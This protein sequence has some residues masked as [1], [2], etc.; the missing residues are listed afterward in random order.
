M[1]EQDVNKRIASIS[2]QKRELLMQL[3]ERKKKQ[4]PSPAAAEKALP[5]RAAGPSP[6]SFAQQ[7]LWFMDQWETEN[8]FS[9]IPTAVILRGVLDPGALARAIEAVAQRH[10]ILRTTFQSVEGQLLQIVAPQPT[11]ALPLEDLS[12]LPQAERDAALHDRLAR[13]ARSGFDLAQGPLFRTLLFKLSSTEHVLM[14]TMHHIVTDGWSNAV[15]FREVSAFYTAFVTSPSVP[16]PGAPSGVP[17]GSEASPAAP[18]SPSLPPLPLQ[19]ADYALWQRQHLDSGVRERQVAYWKQQLAGASALELPTDRPRPA[20]NRY[21]GTSLVFHVPGT[22]REKVEALCRRAGV[23][24]FMALLGALQLLLARLSGADE[25]C[26]GSP[27]AGRNRADLEGLIG[28]FLNNLVLRTDLSGDPTALELL[29][30]VRKVALGAYD[31]QDVPFEQVV[32][33][34]Q[35]PRDPSRTPLFQ[36]MFV[37]QGGWIQE[38]RLGDLALSP[39]EVASSISKFDLTWALADADDGFQGWIEYNT[40]LFDRA[41]VERFAGHYGTLLDAL[42][43]TPEK[44]ISELPL[45]SEA[46]RHRALVDWNDTA[47]PYPT[48]TCLHELF[49]Q[50]AACTP[51]AIAVI[52]PDRRLTYR[53][54]ER[55]ANRLAHALRARGATPNTLAAVVIRKG[56]AQVVAALA[57]LKAGAAYVPIDPG[58]PSDRVRHLLQH[59]EVTLALTHSTLADVIAWPPGV[60]HFVVDADLDDLSEADDRAPTR[61]QGPLDLAYVIYTSGSTGVPKGVMI[62]HRGPVNTIVDIN[63]RFRVGPVDRVLAL[64]ALNFDLSVYDVFGLLAV[65]GALVL[66]ESDAARDPAYWAELIDRERIT[67][68]NTVPALMEM[69]VDH[70]AEH[71][72]SPHGPSIAAAPLPLRAALLSGDWIPVTLPDRLKRIIPGIVVTSLGGAT[73][74]SIWSILYPIDHVDPTW[75]S[76]PYGRAMDNQRF[77]VLD[78]ALSPCPIGVEGDLYIGGIGVALGYWRAEEIT[79]A[80][81]ITDPRT[82]ERLYRTGDAGRYMVDGN[83]EFLGRRDFQVKIRGF[84]IELGEIEVTLMNHPSVREALVVVREDT[85]GDRRLVAY[86]VGNDGTEPDPAVLKAHAQDKLPEYM[87]P[88]AF[89]ALPAMPLTPNGKVDRRALPRPET[90]R[91]TLAEHD[92]DF[93]APRSPHETTLAGIW[94]EVIGL[95]RVGIHDNFFSLGG[96]SILAIQVVNRAKRAGISLAVR[97]LFQHQTIAAL[98]VLSDGSERP[99]AEQGPVTG[100]VV[101][102]P[103]QRWFFEQDRSAPEHFNQAVLAEIDERLDPA[104]VTQAVVHLVRHHDALRLRFVREGGEVQQR[105]AEVSDETPFTFVTLPAEAR[106]ADAGSQRPTEAQARAIVAAAEQAQASLRL[107]TGPLLRVVLMDLGEGQPSR[108]LFVVH[109]LAIDGVSWRILLEDFQTAYA[110]LRAGEEVRFPPKTSSFQQWAERLAAHAQTEAVRRELPHWLAASAPLPI[111]RDLPGGENLASSSATVERTLDPEETRALLH[112]LPDV[113]RTQINDVLLTALTQAFSAWTG[114]RA[115]QL[116]LEGHGREDLGDDLDLSRTVGWFTALYPV[117]LDLPDGGPGERLKAIKEQLRRIPRRG[118]G[119][120]LLRYLATEPDVSGALRAHP[121]ADV[122]FNYQGHVEQGPTGER[123][124]RAAEEPS[125]APHSPHDPRTHL[126]EIGAWIADGRLHLRWTYSDTTH[127]RATLERLADGF[128]TA[129]RELLAH[130]REPDAGGRTPADFPLVR[131]TQSALDRLVGHGRDVEDLYPLSP[132]QQGMLFHSLRDPG[133]GVYV[134]QLAFR[135][136]G[137]LD[138]AALQASWQALLARHPILRTAFVHGDLDEP[139]QLVRP[140]AALTWIQYDWRALPPAERAAQL[141]AFM[142]RD[143]ARGFDLADAPLMRLTV[144]R[145]ED[146]AHEL[147]W[148][149]HHLLLDGWSL[150]IVFKDLLTAYDA[151]Q[152]GEAPRLGA[153]RP[154]R[155]YIAW[156]AEQD[157][158]Q[159]EAFWRARLRGFQAPTPLPADRRKSAGAEASTQRWEER[160]LTPEITSALLDLSRAHG[161]T[162][163]T[164]LQGAWAL[165]LGRSSGERDVVFGATVSGRSASVDGIEEMVGLFINTPPVRVRC[166]ADATLV[167]WLQGL[168]AQQA[169]QLPYEYTPLT[170]VQGFSEVARGEPLFES[171]LVVENYPM[172]AALQQSGGPLRV[173]DVRA[174]EQ[175]SYPLTVVAAVDQGI[176]LRLGYDPARFEG[177]TILRLLDHLGALLE[178]ITRRPEQTVASLSLLTPA[179][180]TQV[181]TTWNDTETTF[182]TDLLVHR[183]IEAQAARTPD[184]IALTF[185][186]EHLTYRALNC[187]ANQLA[188]ALRAHGV[189]P[190]VLVGVAAERSFELVVA[191]L[192]TLKAGGAYVPLDPAYPTERLRLMIEE[193]RP[194]VILTQQ[195]LH[196][197]LPDDGPPAL[198]LDAE[199]PQI[200]EER[201]ADL[202]LSPTDEGLVYVIYTSGSTGRPKGVMNNHAGLRNRL[203][204]M[205][206]AYG[207]TAEDVVLQKTPYSFDVSVWEF[208]W[209]LMFGARL[210]VA[211][212]EGHRDP[213]YLRDLI[214]AEGVTTLHFVPSMLKAMVDH[215][216]L[217]DCASVKRVICSGEALPFDL[218]ERFF[219]QSQA[220]LHNLYGPTEAS[221]DVT[222]WACRP[223]DPRGVV[224]IGAPIA[225]TRI[226]ILDER[227]DPTPVGVPGELYIGG[228][229][230]ARGYLRRPDLTAARFVPDPHGPPGARLY[231][232]G[233]RVR[234][235]DDGVIEYLERLDFQVKIR[236]FRIELGEIEAA[237]VQHPAVRDGVVVVREDASGEPRLVAYLVPR[238]APEPAGAQA[239][240]DL[241]P[242]AL[243]AFLADRLPGHMIPAAFVSVPAALPLTSSGKV[244][245]RALPAPSAEGQDAARTLTSPRTPTEEILAGIWAEVLGTSTI[246]AHDDFFALGGHSLLATQVV[247]RARRSFS[248]ELPL[249]TVFD[250]PT[251]TALA[252]RIDIARGEGVKP[253]L[254]ALRRVTS[255]PPDAA[256]A[257]AGHPLSF[258]QQRMWV[259]DQL[260]PGSPWYNIPLAVRIDGPLDVAVL[261]RCLHDLAHRHEPLRTTF[262]TVEGEPRQIIAA[263]G[264]IPLEIVEVVTSGE[265]ATGS[266]AVSTTSAAAAAEALS[267]A[268]LQALLRDE[269]CRPFDLATGPLV[270]ARLVKLGEARHAF[271]LTMHHIVADGWSIGVIMKELALLYAARVEGAPATLPPLEIQYADYAAWQHQWLQGDTLDAQLTF[272]KQHLAGALDPLEL[273]TDCPRPALQSPR[274]KTRPL[275]IPAPLK[276]ALDALC[277]REGV[278]LFMALLAGFQ[279]LLGRY[280]G[281]DTVLV[282][283]PVAGRTQAATEDLVG[284]F[285]NTLV[286][287]ADLGD[288]PTFRELLARVKRSTLDAYAH[289]DT[290]FEKLVSALELPRDTSRPPLF[291]AM[292]VLQNLPRA[293]L[294]SGALTLHPIALATET[295]KF[296][297]TLLLDETDEGLRGGLEYSTALFDAA[298]IDRMAEAFEAFLTR[299]AQAPDKRLSALSAPPEPELHTLLSVWNAPV[300]EP[301]ADLCA[302]HLI[303]QQVARTPDAPAVTLGDVTLTYAELD[304][305]ANALAHRLQA[306]GVGPDV[307]VAL[308]LDRSPELIVALLGVLKAGGAYVPLDPSYPEERVAFMLDDSQAAVVV[309]H[310]RVPGR[311]PPAAGARH[312]LLADDGWGAPDAPSAPDASGAPHASS[313]PPKCPATPSNLAYLLYTSGSTGRPKGVMVPH[314]GLASYLRWSAEAYGMASGDGVPVHSSLAF[315]L[316]VTSALAPLTVGQR[317]HLIPEGPGIEHLTTALNEGRDHALLKLTPSHLDALL[318]DPTAQRSLARVRSFVVGGEALGAST[319]TALRTHAP[320]ARILNEYGPTETVVGCALWEVPPDFTPDQPVL[321]GKPIPGARLYVLDAQGTPAPIGVRGELCIGG[322]GVTRGY[323]GRPA[324]TAERFVPDPFAT[325]P[326]AR[327]YRSGD[328]ARF[329]AD[330]QLDYLGRLDHQVKVR[331]YRIE[332]GEIEHALTA[333]P[334]LREAVVLARDD[335]PS[336]RRLVG[337]LVPA[338]DSPMPSMTALREALA[339]TLPAYMVPSAFVVLDA[340]PL[341][342]NG[343]VDR[344]A[345]PSPDAAPSDPERP[346]IA[347]ATPAEQILVDVLRQVLRLDGI[348]THHNFFDLGGDSI[349]AIQVVNKAHLAGL[350]LTFR[351]ILE[352]PTVADLA[353]VATEADG[354]DG[355]PGAR[356]HHL[357]AANAEQGLVLGDVPPIAIQRWFFERELLMPAHYNQSILVEI[358][359]RLDPT[360]LRAAVGALLQHHDVLRLRVVRGEQGPTLRIDPPGDDIPFSVVNLADVPSDLQ[361]AAITEAAAI[362]QASLDLG[363]GPL[364]RVALFDLG[365]ERPGRL[366]FVAHHL[367]VDGVSWRILPEDLQTA[368]AQLAAGQPVRLPRKTTSFKAWADR[369][370]AHAQTDAIRNELPFWLDSAGAPPL[371]LDARKGPNTAASERTVTARLSPEETRALLEDVPRSF[372]TRI[373]D[374]L[375]TALGL[376]LAPWFGSRSVH[377]DL[378]GHGREPFADDLDP[379][380][381]VGWFT[382]IFPVRIDLPQEAT[383]DEALPTLSLETIATAVQQQLRAIPHGGLGYGLLRHLSESPQVRAALRAMPGSQILFNYLGQFDQRLADAPALRVARES[384]GP[385]MAP[386]ALRSHLLEIN[387]RVVDGQLHVDW[388][389]SDNLH[390]ARTIEQLAARFTEA[391]R[392]FCALSATPEARRRR[393]ARERSLL[394]KI[395]PEGRGRPVFFVHGGTGMV[396]F[397]ATLARLLGKDR[398]FYAIQAKG[399]DGEAPNRRIDTMAAQYVEM[400]RAVQPEGPYLLGGYSFGALVAYE[401]ACQLSQAGEEVR[402]LAL[403]D[404]PPESSTAFY[405][406]WDDTHYLS[407]IA[408]GLGLDLPVDTLRPLARL[409]QLQRVVD[410]ARTTGALPPDIGTLEV[411]RLLAIYKAHTEARITYAPPTY[412]QHLTLYRLSEEAAEPDGWLPGIRREDALGW[413]RYV[414][415]PV[416]LHE[417]SGEHESMLGEPH[418]RKLAELLKQALHSADP[419]T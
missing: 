96:D 351:D 36:V 295:A 151:C 234:W 2:P 57:I 412:D 255:D 336:D 379:S 369:L 341:T 70:L 347:P 239:G 393:A 404:M 395:Q 226:Y 81:F 230:L 46:Q 205:Q 13:D 401:M 312:L 396:L 366:F 220:E 185:E 177:S 308:W 18:P 349:L 188:H 222:F 261:A 337:Y 178:G 72:A 6:A 303:E 129:L 155:D 113:Y 198:A 343:K 208:F 256:S 189:G 251:L 387:G 215:P 28:L 150:P 330:G 389:Y 22:T 319:I 326:G 388:G 19:Y 74:A 247:A 390:D 93:V 157:L 406:G 325:E 285:I 196:H 316:T 88:A 350:G 95:E 202:A 171:I 374:V 142:D 271:Q 392:G 190:D 149:H 254:P 416:R 313:A 391:L 268:A 61:V 228:V 187:R 292:F 114:A 216:G 265:V 107:D 132:T 373:N 160:K 75:R 278:T 176:T 98:S 354:V 123:L 130:G 345:L 138:P 16:S 195:R 376:A 85:P 203:L 121:H 135:I 14:L 348:S 90:T 173:A 102:T 103:I 399:I 274:G 76:I 267:D 184:A 298:T 375:L 168:Q 269:A 355:T 167:A 200:A 154:Y 237:L 410:G 161:L 296:E 332:L 417:V 223:H 402:H 116:D 365:P 68:W 249:R 210:V 270:R 153:V 306:L 209:P 213:V 201:D 364:L 5:P 179:A 323:H 194:A 212:P 252:E 300:P 240:T 20:V 83:I 128:T 246:G 407:D 358:D 367:V 35:P 80:A 283:S 414:Q 55:R 279:A 305:R 165:L 1:S 32:D 400:L 291:Q 264:T 144:F 329:R 162:P 242:A 266:N 64:S 4:Q 243:R 344:R 197:L 17:G 315:D 164:L 34:V 111:P 380:R 413:A 378:E 290:P 245:R 218:Q 287:R 45:L 104:L 158:A 30:R 47:A 71:V 277:R 314:R 82:G 148:T 339:R 77:Y 318:G 43:T 397:Y 324:L 117:R 311:L 225:N 99:A 27:V 289:Q 147:V 408:R 146:E 262:A 217:V 139:L 53:E 272:W 361:A 368:Y 50:Q 42:A 328:L 382:T 3:L 280:A 340:L 156:L 357:A 227:L 86:V 97:N 37:L 40:D 41:T 322:L 48:D 134:E 191:L 301:I 182:A 39:V 69:L 335:G 7:R 309:S 206:R 231:R 60:E 327:L 275:S 84:R 320:H 317:V 244:D 108:L 169:E 31:H 297:L 79:R 331:G 118:L 353:R 51:D 94:A 276:G 224:P 66:P 174:R 25:V 221:I 24:R 258:A 383:R 398:P 342:P 122:V 204:W 133:S 172:D 58:L 141:D 214:V 363:A 211:R 29:E 91:A 359:D 199:W 207:L 9:N 409:E 248:V 21:R 106:D 299:A 321:I 381:T 352:Q 281:Q 360:L 192:A 418:V 263:E 338:A 109:H 175:T 59:G 238:D 62:D 294:R 260:Q 73:E 284:L 181:L 110:Q 15:F 145:T 124:F 405:D 120:G 356:G 394:V 346:L 370:V 33:A 233:D 235:R 140:A 67:L 229:G 11:V 87:V 186:G 241:S 131:I 334:G 159:A 384:S 112:D 183:Q 44:R 372:G 193:S 10:E 411:S 273:P 236:G 362:L 170:L 232:T 415:Q 286:L 101:L 65:G 38:S 288:D 119:H 125:G 127:H 136:E 163:N 115:L 126:I 385:H 137:K 403:F 250:A 377:I 419:V 23:T 105:H 219:A 56:W 166:D 143:R 12:A 52:A 310:S 63:R 304:H 180:R 333:L 78:R 293:S 282:G 8:A 92:S 26:I 307:P 89:V 371:P 257:T 100:P 253:T 302:H 152:K 386:G 259:L 54:V 49:E